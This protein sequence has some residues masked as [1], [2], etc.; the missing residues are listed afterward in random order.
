[1]PLFFA[2]HHR[3]SFVKLNEMEAMEPNTIID[4]IAVVKSFED[5]ASITTK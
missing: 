3:Y 5:C 1:M 2:D 4:V